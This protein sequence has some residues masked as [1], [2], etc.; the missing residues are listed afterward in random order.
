MLASY[1]RGLGSCWIGFAQGWLETKEVRAALDLPL[2][3]QPVALI[4]IGHPAAAVSAA[5]RKK[6]ELRWRGGGASAA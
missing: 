3:W 1:G 6:P 5:P 4:I 2:H